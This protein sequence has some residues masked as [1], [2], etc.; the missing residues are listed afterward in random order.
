MKVV[1]SPNQKWDSHT[2][3]KQHRRLFHW[4]GEEGAGKHIKKSVWVTED[5][6]EIGQIKRQNYG[7]YLFPDHLAIWLRWNWLRKSWGDLN[8]LVPE[9]IEKQECW[10]AIASARC[11]VR[12]NIPHRYICHIGFYSVCYMSLLSSL[13]LQSYAQ[14]LSHHCSW[15]SEETFLHTLIC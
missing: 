7:T 12:N 9:L 10:N 5:D 14:S 3:N 13:S 8:L 6:E 4:W 11:C 1:S 2:E 15:L